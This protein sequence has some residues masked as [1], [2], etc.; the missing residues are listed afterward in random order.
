M[1]KSKI[2]PLYGIWLVENNQHYEFLSTSA[3][4]LRHHLDELSKKED[5]GDNEYIEVY[6]EFVML[7]YNNPIT[8]K[9]GLVNRDECHIL[10]H[11][12]EYYLQEN[13]YGIPLP[14]AFA[15]QYG[16]MQSVEFTTQR[17]EALAEH[18]KVSGLFREIGK[19]LEILNQREKKSLMKKIKGFFSALFS[20]LVIIMLLLSILR[21]LDGVFDLINLNPSILSVV[22]VLNTV[23][24][25]LI[26]ANVLKASSVVLSQVR[27]DKYYREFVNRMKRHEENI[28]NISNFTVSY[29][30]NNQKLVPSSLHPLALSVAFQRKLELFLA[31]GGQDLEKYLQKELKPK[32]ILVLIGIAASFFVL[33]H[34]IVN[35]LRLVTIAQLLNQSEDIIQ[36]QS[37]IDTQLLVVEEV[38]VKEP[39]TMKIIIE[40]AQLFDLN[41]N[42]IGV[43]SKNDI[44]TLLSDRRTLSEGEV[45]DKVITSSGVEGWIRISEMTWTFDN[46][47]VVDSAMAS[48][49]IASDYSVENLYDFEHTTVWQEGVNGPGIGENIIFDYANHYD[50]KGVVIVNGNC[51]SEKKYD[52]NNRV[53]K[54]RI[55]FSDGTEQLIELVDEYGPQGQLFE[56]EKSINTK[57]IEI[58]IEE[59]YSGSRFDDTCLSE[60]TV[61]Y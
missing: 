20:L 39:V 57:S 52:Q 2:M 56:F 1:D 19:K 61:F 12:L 26:L 8:L 3:I 28:K 35:D 11:E 6:Y 32:R 34:P 9:I 17:N 10:T 13:S 42:E 54:A 14:I 60:I 58:V 50:I 21:N 29:D 51:K 33:Y 24:M 16:N 48:S 49:I 7:F 4:A 43:V 5:V 47:A 40:K 45:V 22:L 27:S 38:E 44:V 55:I 36:G 31:K 23:L 30:I 46:I 25:I 37:E 41:N 15:K 59:V 18:H 53:K